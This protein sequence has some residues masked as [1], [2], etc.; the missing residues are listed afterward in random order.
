MLTADYYC[1]VWHGSFD[2]NDIELQRLLR[3]AA[4]TINNAIYLSG[5]D[6]DTVTPE[7]LQERVNNAVCAQADFINACGGVDAMF[8]ADEQSV[9]LGKFSYTV[10]TSN[11]RNSEELCDLARKYLLPTGLL[12]RGAKIL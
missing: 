1:N 6:V 12:Y 5:M 10:D 2:G 4:D 8:E 7:P 11:Q 3:R 9:T